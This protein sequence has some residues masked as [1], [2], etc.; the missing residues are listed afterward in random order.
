MIQT[1]KLKYFILSL[2][3]ATKGFKNF[4]LN[5]LKR[6]MKILKLKIIL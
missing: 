5:I 3:V 1:V 6:N 2:K 4:V